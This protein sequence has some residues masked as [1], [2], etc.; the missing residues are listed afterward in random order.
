MSGQ[1]PRPSAS[2]GAATSG[3]AV[4][5]GKMAM[6]PVFEL[7]ATIPKIPPTVE[8]VASPVFELPATIPEIPPPVER[9][10]GGEQ[11]V[12]RGG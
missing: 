9:V 3:R 8:R 6:S 2:A 12:V 1:L 11:H 4:I 7:P 10:T 5:R